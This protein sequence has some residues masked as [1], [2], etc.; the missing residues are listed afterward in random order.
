MGG[1]DWTAPHTPQGGSPPARLQRRRKL[2]LLLPAME[3]TVHWYSRVK[4]FF[5]TKL[6][7]IAIVGQEV[8]RRR[9]EGGRAGR[10]G[11]RWERKGG[12]GKGRKR[13]K[14]GV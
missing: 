13:R 11:R 8:G 6:R 5:H 1:A 12:E 4:S 2:W 9:G 7:I 14:E 10:T 3:S